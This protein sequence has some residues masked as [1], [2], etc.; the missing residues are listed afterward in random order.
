[1]EHDKRKFKPII[2]SAPAIFGFYEAMSFVRKS[3]GK[4]QLRI[5]PF[6]I[7]R[8]E[9]MIKF[10]DDL[11]LRSLILRKDENGRPF[12]D[13]LNKSHMD[14]I[15]GARTILRGYENCWTHF[16][17]KDFSFLYTPE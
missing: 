15:I 9:V 12:L 10:I 13:V 3:G 16:G 11:R 1:M 8:D 7:P 4:A 14:R 2:W 5:N 17:K 6:P